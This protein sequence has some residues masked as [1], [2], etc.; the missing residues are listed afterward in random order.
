[1]AISRGKKFLDFFIHTPVGEEILEG[2]T[3][4]LLAGGALIG[5]E[6]SPEEIAL[7]TG[8]GI[9]KDLSQGNV[10]DAAIKTGTKY[11]KDN[12]IKTDILPLNEQLKIG[13]GN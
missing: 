3:Q 9:V 4:G 2:T 13:A 12:L 7:K 10:K 5:T 6:Q 11:V 1:M 8:A